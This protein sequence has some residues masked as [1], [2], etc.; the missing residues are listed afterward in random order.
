MFRSHLRACSHRPSRLAALDA[1]ALLLTSSTVALDEPLMPNFH[2]WAW[3]WLLEAVAPA[4]APALAQPLTRSAHQPPNVP[5]AA[6]IS[7]ST[8]WRT[9]RVGDG[10]FDNVEA[11]DGD[12]RVD[13]SGGGGSGG[14]GG[15][16]GGGGSGGG[17]G[18]GGG[19]LSLG[20]VPDAAAAGAVAAGAAAVHSQCAVRQ[21]VCV[22]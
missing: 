15:G 17:G 6:G 8:D 22:G 19:G 16:G 11:V 21:R 5:S 12:D 18:G 2:A 9:A 3:A 4:V 7:L 10:A 14:G 1:V 20:P 13:G